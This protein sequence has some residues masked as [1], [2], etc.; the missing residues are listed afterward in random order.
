MSFQPYVSPDRKPLELTWRAVVLGTLLAIVFGAGNAF[1]GLKV[2]MTVSASIPAAVI[3]MAVLRTM[4]R[5]STILE[6]NIVQTIGS[7]GESLAAGVIFT[8][9]ALIFLGDAPSSLRIF[10]ISLLGGLLGILFMIPLRRYLIVQEHGR[11]PYPEGTACAEILKAGEEGGSR[12]WLVVWGTLL[13]GLHKFAASALH[14]FQEVPARTLGFLQNTAVSLEATPSLLGVG[15]IVGPRIAAL[16]LAGGVLGWLVFIPLIKLVGS[17]LDAPIFPGT[18]PIAEMGAKQIWSNYIRYIGAGAVAMGGL[19]SLAKAFPVILRSFK[20]GFKEIARGLSHREAA[21]RTEDDLPMGLVVAGSAAIIIALWLTPGM[22]MNL[23]SLTVVVVMGFFFVTVASLTVGLLG[24]STNPVSGMTITTLLVT[25]LLFVTMGWTDAG[26]M[27]AAMVVGCVVCIAICMAGDASQDLKTGYLLG[28]TPRLQQIAEFIGVV[29]P[30]TVM[31]GTLYLLHS[32]YGLGSEKLS[33][34]QA[35]LMSMV[36]KGVLEG[37]LPWTLVIL[38]M[39]SGACVELMGIGSL[40]FAI[41]LYLPMSLSTPIMAG[42]LV[43]WAVSRLARNNP[44]RANDRGVLVSS[45][46]VAGDALTGVLVALLV[47]LKMVNIEVEPRLGTLASLGAFAGLAI[48]LGTFSLRKEE[49]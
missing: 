46:L 21:L 35:T 8:I 29:F 28:A 24:S 23:L 5:G 2:G 10:W 31:G 27:L 16:M 43:A 3:S 11:L 32:A 25:C 17:G 15:F 36:V 1:L 12:A 14:I 9:P 6:N 4:F 37:S 45:G 49:R 20:L 40:P 13:G 22:K 34:P 48:L 19:V 44:E 26:Y 39:A 30:A 42:G 47:V 33:A 41:G 7:S 38:G 18:V